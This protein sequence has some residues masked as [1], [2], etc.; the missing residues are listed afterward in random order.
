IGEL[1]MCT[2]QT[3]LDLGCGTGV[4]LPLL[5]AKV[6]PAGRVVGVDA[7]E[8]MLHEARKLGRDQVAELLQ[9]DAHTLPFPSGCADWI[10]CQGLLPHLH[11]P[12]L[13][14][15][16]MRRVARPRGKLVIFHA[17]GRVQLAAMHQKTPSDDEVLA[18]PRLRPLLEATG[19][20]VERLEDAPER[21]LAVG[22]AGTG[23]LYR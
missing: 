9:G 15:R 8:A 23:K 16:E 17:M 5:R 18:P 10:Y 20:R 3:V 4:A 6:G 22:C 19:W 11:D 12:A 14:L 13:A 2:G 1:G 21:F 7:T